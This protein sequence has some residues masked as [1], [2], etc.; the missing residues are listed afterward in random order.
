[1][2]SVEFNGTQLVKDL[3]VFAKVQ[4]PFVA[5]VT[6]NRL[7]T[8]VRKDLQ[9][10]ILDSF[11]YVSAFTYKSPL[12]RH[13]ASKAEPWTEVYLKDEAAKGQAP[14]QY[15]L[16]QITGG[17]VLRT[18]FQRRATGAGPGY[19]VPLLDSPA[20]KLNNIGR[21][22]PAQYTEALYGIK[23]MEDVRAS[24]RPGKY[25]TEG[26]Y[27]F[28]GP[29]LNPSKRKRKGGGRNLIGEG[30]G[31][32]RVMGDDYVQL[33]KLLR[34]TPTVEKRFD[35]AYASQ[36]SVE[37]NVEKIFDKAISEFVWRP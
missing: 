1:M 17:P 21:I 4:L 23:A 19:L 11:N 26:S 12:Q 2:A 8:Q 20:A 6:V 16:P 22:S 32:Y 27:V 10:E 37:K 28:I 36:L 24:M 34:R 30:Y 3:D 14:A 18:R 13:F 31:I 35:F 33:F 29:S 9:R 5:A 25:R 15:L 7:A